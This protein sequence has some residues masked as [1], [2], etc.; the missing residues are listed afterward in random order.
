[1]YR[2]QNT[3][4]IHVLHRTVYDVF[5]FFPCV[6]KFKTVMPFEPFGFNRLTRTADC[7]LPTHESQVGCTTHV[8][9]I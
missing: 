2:G 4:M 6:L 7:R 8:A 1:M 3:V 9:R 5:F